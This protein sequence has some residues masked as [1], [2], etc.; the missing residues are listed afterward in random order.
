[1]SESQAPLTA[2]MF[3]VLI[4]LADGDKHGYAILKEVE[5]QTAGEVQ[6]STGTLYGIIKRLLAE[7]LIVESRHRPAEDDDQRRRYYRLTDPGRQVAVVEAMRMER[8]LARAR[9]KRLL[10]GAQTGLVGANVQCKRIV[11][12]PLLPRPAAHS[13][14]RFPQRVWRRHGRDVPRTASRH[15]P[16]PGQHG[17]LSYVVGHDHRYRSHGA[18]RAPQRA[19]ARHALRAPHDAQE[20]RVHAGRGPHPGARH[21]R[22]HVHLLRGELR[23]AAAAA[24]LARQSAGD[25]APARRQERRHRH[26]LLRL[27]DQR[28][29]AEESQPERVGGVPRH[30]LHPAG[31]HRTAPRAHRRGLGRILPVPGS[32]ARPG[33][34]F[35][36]RRRTGGRGPGSD[37]ELRVL[38]K[39]GA[40]RPQHHRQEVP[41]ERSCP[42]RDRSPAGRFRSIPT[43]TTST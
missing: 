32:A 33:T 25:S 13:A 5:E 31:R 16:T 23:A 24:L 38:E 11:R 7:G 3:N 39:A 20:P 10:E 9:N 26:A 28:L 14:V 41:D 17:Y 22:Q 18:A 34:H 29:P 36:A 4:T 27:G 21:R 42:S 37:S 2:A 19:G 12:R 8:V 15:D 6:L 43:R 30:D 1:M 35:R 40:R